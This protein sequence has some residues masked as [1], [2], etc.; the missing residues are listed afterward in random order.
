ML[1]EAVFWVTPARVEVVAQA[2]A[3]EDPTETDD[4][5][6]APIEGS[7]L[8]RWLAVSLVGDGEHTSALVF[9]VVGEQVQ[10]HRDGARPLVAEL[11]VGRTSTFTLAGATVIAVDPWD[12]P[13]DQRATYLRVDD[14]GIHRIEVP[15]FELGQ[16]ARPASPLQAAVIEREQRRIAREVVLSFRRARLVESGYRESLRTALGVLGASAITIDE[17][18]G[19][20]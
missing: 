15:P 4:S 10:A 7:S 2:A 16:P 6:S 13:P 12:A 17:I 11:P 20:R 14:D 9:D 3:L 8:P 1:R 18:T 5:V 19:E